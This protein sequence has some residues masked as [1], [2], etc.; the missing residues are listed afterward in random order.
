MDPHLTLR[1]PAVVPF[2]PH[3]VVHEF[4][5][6][7]QRIVQDHFGLLLLFLVVSGKIRVNVSE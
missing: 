6:T 5:A 2:Q 7:M 4:V 1:F 3:I